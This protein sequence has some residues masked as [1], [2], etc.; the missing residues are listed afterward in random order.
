MRLSTMVARAL[1]VERTV[2]EKVEVGGY[3]RSLVVHVRPYVKE[4]KRCPVC[5]ESCPRYDAGEGVRRWRGHDFGLVQVYLVAEAP[6]VRCLLHGVR[7]A[8]VPWARPRSRFT[9]GFE[10]QVAWFATKTDKTTLS[11]VLH[12]AWR[13]V[14]RIVARVYEEQRALRDPLD[15]LTRIGIDE[16]S[17]RKGHRYLTVVIDHETGR[18]VWAA[19]GRSKKT[20]RKFFRAL[21]KKRRAAIQLVSADAASWIATTVRKECPNA[22]LCIDPF[23]VVAWATKA[24]DK[25][26]RSLWNKLRKRGEQERAKAMKG[27]RWALLKNPEGLSRRQKPP[28]R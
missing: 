25:V 13:T 6:R 5:L 18:L 10:D 14:G 24:L 16:V 20:L 3:G 1:G 7:V 12:V 27:S 4:Q 9:R 23:H 17:Y 11:K 8:H 22:K 26:R 15:G 19:P 28:S 21:G 2:V